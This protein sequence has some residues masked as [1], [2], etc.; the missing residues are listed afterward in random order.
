MSCIFLVES[1]EE[2]LAGPAEENPSGMGKFLQVCL[3][4]FF[5]IPGGIPE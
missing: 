4:N 5:K 1:L 2:F 3:E